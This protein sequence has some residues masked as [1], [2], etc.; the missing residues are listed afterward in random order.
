MELT[1][2]AGNT[3]IGFMA[4][5]G[6]ARIAPPGCRLSWHPVTQIAQFDGIALDALLDHLVAHMR[7]RSASRE[8][9]LADCARGMTF[10]R[11]REIVTSERPEVLDWARAWWRENGPDITPTDL[12]FVSG[13]QRMIRMARDLAQRLDPGHA[14]GGAQAVREKF[15]EALLGPWKYQDDVASWGWDP[16]TLRPGAM[17]ATDPAK[18]PMEGVAAAYWLAWESQPFFPQ[19]PGVG[20]L[21]YVRRPSRWCWH[22]WAEPLEAEA[23]R[24]ILLRPDEAVAL[25][26][27]R[28]QSRR[29]SVGKY[30][31]LAPGEIV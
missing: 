25:G 21:G 9:Q 22:T 17:T 6:L 27:K 16:A 4:A 31:W 14:K 2:L 12:C 3:P 7:N 30:G 19:I 23:V 5:V 11:Y 28:Y 18:T 24:A 15:R 1:G 8:L 10:E 29:T 26:G 20:T 13:Q